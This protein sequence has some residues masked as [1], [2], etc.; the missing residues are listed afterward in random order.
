VNLASF[1]K[2]FGQNG[3]VGDVCLPAYDTFFTDSLPVIDQAC[4]SFVPPK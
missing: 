2:K 4:V 1:T 3:F